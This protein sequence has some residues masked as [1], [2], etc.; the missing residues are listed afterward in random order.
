MQEKES[1]R[2]KTIR[3]LL[4]NSDTILPFAKYALPTATV[5]LIV[6]WSARLV[7]IFGQYAPFSWIVAG[8]LA[9]FITALII[10]ILAW[11]YRTRIRAKYDAKFLGSSGPINPLAKTFEAQRIYLN[12]FC[13]PSHPFIDDK[14][15]INCE[16]I[17]PA[18][19]M[20]A[21]GNSATENIQPPLDAVLLNGKN[22][23][24]NGYAFRNC[25]FR[26]CSFQRI[27]FFV[28]PVEYHLYKDH[29]MLN[30]ISATQIDEPLLPMRGT[31]DSI[32]IGASH[33]EK[34][35]PSAEV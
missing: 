10:A 26:K 13:L 32:M 28:T 6:S 30:W 16:I 24:T 31:E 4:S 9:A 34:G 35:D 15:F 29:P 12:D 2:Q 7:G 8:L 27:T 18:N 22:P 14:T 19:I 5:G 3:F 1:F 11:A 17:G 21:V 25:I 23:F 20:F 33:E